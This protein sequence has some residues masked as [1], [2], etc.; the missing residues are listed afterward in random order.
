MNIWRLGQVH[1]KDLLTKFRKEKKLSFEWLD[2]TVNYKKTEVSNYRGWTCIEPWVSKM[3][4]GD[5]IFLISRYY[6]SGFGLVLDEYKFKKYDFEIGREIRP[7]IPVKFI[8]VLK[9]PIEHNFNIKHTNPR[10]FSNISHFGFNLYFVMQFLKENYLDK[11]RVMNGLI[12]NSNDNENK[13]TRIC[14]NDRDWKGPSGKNGKNKSSD[15]FEGKYGFGFE[16]WLNEQSRI[17]EGYHYSFIQSLGSSKHFGKIYNIALVKSDIHGNRFLAGKIKNG[18]CISHQESADIFAIY[19]SKNWLKE[20]YKEIESVGGKSI[21]FRTQQP[22]FMFNI[23]YKPN[24]IMIYDESPILPD[25]Y[26]PTYRYKLLDVN[27]DNL[28]SIMNEEIDLDEGNFKSTS[29]IK[30]G[31][32]KGSS[33]DPTHN[34]M[35]NSLT[36]LLRSRTDIYNL[37]QIEKN[38]IDIKARTLNDEW[39]FYEIKTCGTAKKAIRM[40]IGQIMEYAYWPDIR[41]A[42]KLI[43]V[44]EIEPGPSTKKYMKYLRH[45][46]HIPIYYQSF[47]LPA[48]LGE[49]V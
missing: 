7:G 37:V 11:Y 25:D 16:E 24:N 49:L 41:K 18:I 40:A 17:I 33:Y 20:M 32:S 14:W 1:S 6:Y 39:H 38:R 26:L 12:N 28:T 47:N 29:T 27:E 2:A 44:S 43:I 21:Y 5:I 34:N 4:K 19:Q 45:K 22:G 36:R 46:F 31:T 23:K 15:T 8:H 3:K 48:K 10:T 42:N 30:K 13:I 9:A 35:Q